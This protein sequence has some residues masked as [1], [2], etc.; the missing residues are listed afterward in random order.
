MDE[1][2][3][4]LR[5]CAD[6]GDDIATDIGLRRAGSA[7]NSGG[8]ETLVMAQHA[9]ATKALFVLATAEKLPMHS[10]LPPQYR[11][12]W[13]WWAARQD[14]HLEAAVQEKE[15][16]LSA[17]VQS[18]LDENGD[19]GAATTPRT[20]EHVPAT[21]PTTQQEDTR[22]AD[23][24]RPGAALAAGTSTGITYGGSSGAAS[25]APTARGRR[26]RDEFLQRRRRAVADPRSEFAVLQADRKKL[27][28]F[29][30]RD[31][32]LSLV[33]DNAAVIVSGQTGCG[34]STQLPQYVLEDAL[35]SGRADM[36]NI[37][38]TQ[39][40]RIAAMA[41]AS[42]VG[43]EIGDNL[44]GPAR[45][46]SHTR[47]E[48]T[49]EGAFYD[50][51]TESGGG[52]GD[53]DGSAAPALRRDEART[54]GET[55]GGGAGASSRLVGY[56]VRGEAQCSRDTRLLFCTTGVLL[57]K[58]QSDPSLQNVSHVIVDEV[59]ERDLQSDF[60]LIV[61][62]R[63]LQSHAHRS[64]RPLRVI[65]MSATLDAERFSRYFSSR[66][67]GEGAGVGMP[68]SSETKEDEG[69]GAC[70]DW[71]SAADAG[72]L[73]LPV[74][75]GRA[76]ASADAALEGSAGS[77]LALAPTLSIPGRTFP[78]ETYFLADAL[79]FTGH[80]IAD[81]DETAVRAGRN[82]RSS[83]I[84][85]AHG[86]GANRVRVRHEVKWDE[87]EKAS[88]R[89][90]GDAKGAVKLDR[91]AEPGCYSKA[92]LTSME[93]VDPSVINYDLILDLLDAL[94][95]E[96][97][98]VPPPPERPTELAVGDPGVAAD[99]HG[100]VLIFLPGLKEIRTLVGAIRSSHRMGSAGGS[101]RGRWLWPVPVHSTLPPQ[102]QKRVFDPPPRG[103]AKVI[104]ATNIAET[105]LTISD[106]TTVIDCG[107][108][109]VMQ[110]DG[111]NRTSSLVEVFCSRAHAQQRRGRAGRVAPGRCWRMYPR[112]LFESGMA[113]NTSPEMSRAPLAELCLQVRA[114]G[115]A[116]SCAKFLGEALDPPPRSAVDEA[117]STLYEVGALAKDEAE[118]GVEGQSIDTGE[119]HLTP[120]GRHMAHL[121]LHPRVSKMLLL[122]SLMGSSLEGERASGGQAVLEPVLIVAAAVGLRSPF[123]TPADP[124]EATAVNAARTALMKTAI[125]RTRVTLPHSASDF[126]L[127]ILVQLQWEKVL[128]DAGGRKQSAA[129]RR[130]VDK[131]GL[132]RDTLREMHKL[133]MQFRSLLRSIGFWSPPPA[134]ASAGATSSAVNWSMVHAVV[135]GGMY[136]N[137]ARPER[138]D[139]HRS[140]VRY[141]VQKTGAAGRGASSTRQQ[142]AWVHPS[143]INASAKHAQ[144]MHWLVFHE[145]VRTSRL[146]LRTTMLATPFA[147]LLFG[148]QTMA[149]DHVAR[150]VTA[151]GWIVFR[152]P[153]KTALV[154][155]A[156]RSELSQVL[157]QKLDEPDA[158]VGR[159]GQALIGAVQKLLESETRE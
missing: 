10:L 71:E 80:H 90:A 84:T 38:C 103:A 139:K 57:R 110:W 154:L 159:A 126:M 87:A 8:F 146:F 155:K 99:A 56:Q 50:S 149:V 34:K 59:H 134:G 93:R 54:R 16:H 108:M 130:F 46:T 119:G 63:L 107:R 122:A 96:E 98:V 6:D 13:Q 21:R 137:V 129:E 70:D 75:A 12:V 73:S 76:L 72:M 151:D 25:S 135:C 102:E 125:E 43:L 29:K 5:E 40:R 133:K 68:L 94:F 53:V 127:L 152:C 158:N 114:A 61:L 85:M 52:G 140:V 118:Q 9:V 77:P 106:V 124:A 104:C 131:L 14:R 79:E 33:R 11:R 92:T 144:G 69:W 142:Q 132:H 86:S 30:Y 48:V 42:R 35:E 1:L 117:L 7:V 89:E 28:V 26:M 51:D 156:L 66:G 3:L 109:K 78:I 62:R 148:A 120:L 116:S 22:S 4:C 64:E 37:V 143:S 65:L 145:K 97:R 39:P 88:T 123:M 67:G 91:G 2:G 115:L 41:V 112:E 60:L 101:R 111:L 23:T 44:R 82:E 49:D 74:E 128:E 138:D 83:M 47:H 105:S 20:E 32:F 27:P 15:Q 147:L 157:Q 141:F 113:E 136:P 153:P 45:G 58:L 55:R 100:A 24:R 121:P 150:T 17:A 36:C 95:V 18:L 81:G 19:G 31:K